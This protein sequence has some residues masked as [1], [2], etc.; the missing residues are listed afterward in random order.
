MYI[1]DNEGMFHIDYDI[2]MRE[3]EQI[4][5]D[6]EFGKLASMRM[7]LAWLTDTRPDLEFEVLQITKLTRS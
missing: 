4:P 5:S 3:I 2:K 1:T 7:K 6:A